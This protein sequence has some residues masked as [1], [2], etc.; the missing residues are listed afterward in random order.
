MLRK[1]FGNDVAFDLEDLVDLHLVE[2]RIS[3]EIPWY[4]IP[5]DFT[6]RPWVIRIYA[7]GVVVIKIKVPLMGNY[8][9]N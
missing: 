3:E 4:D 6:K 7:H 2:A 5:W 8:A 1:R 9:N